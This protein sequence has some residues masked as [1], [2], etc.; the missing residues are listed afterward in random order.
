MLSSLS[1]DHVDILKDEVSPHHYKE[2][3]DLKTFKSTKTD[4]GPLK[5]DWKQ[6]SDPLMCSYKAVEVKME[7]WGLQARIEEFIHK[8]RCAYL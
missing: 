6:V 4:R 5:E 3:E 8:V 7:V 2:A 1:V